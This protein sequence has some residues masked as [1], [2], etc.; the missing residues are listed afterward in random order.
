[1]S[2]LPPLSQRSADVAELTDEAHLAIGD[3]AHLFF[4]VVV[5]RRLAMHPQCELGL[6]Q[7]PL[8]STSAL[9]SAVR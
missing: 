7:M 3:E 9:V 6:A 8:T 4:E 5:A 2:H 1:V